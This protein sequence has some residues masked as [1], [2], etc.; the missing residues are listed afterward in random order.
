[1]PRQ[2]QHQHLARRSYKGV[3]VDFDAFSR[4]KKCVVAGGG[5]ASR[6][7]VGKK[8]RQKVDGEKK[9]EDLH[10]SCAAPPRLLGSIVSSDT[11]I[12]IRESER[13]RKREKAEVAIFPSAMCLLLSRT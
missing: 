2:Q 10:Y 8:K 13:E 11:K 12:E 6:G 9:N 1:M 7:M 3:N 4:T 5:N